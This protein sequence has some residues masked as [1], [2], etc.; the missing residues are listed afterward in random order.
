MASSFKVFRLK[1][2]CMSHLSHA[3]YVSRPSNPHSFYTLI[4]FGETPELLTSYS[5]EAKLQNRQK[6][7]VRFY[8]IFNGY[9]IKLCTVKTY[10]PYKK[11]TGIYVR[12]CVYVCTYVRTYVCMYV[13]TYVFIHV[14]RPM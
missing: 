5:I 7:L 12:V 14:C 13:C 10:K 1:F 9:S 4:I 8:F 3:Y 6:S 11:V 2:A